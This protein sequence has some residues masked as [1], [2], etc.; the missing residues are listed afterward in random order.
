MMK[1]FLLKE[2]LR[3]V[4]PFVWMGVVFFNTVDLRPKVSDDFFFASDDPE[5][6]ENNEIFYLFPE[7][8]QPVIISAVGDIRSK[9]YQKKARQFTK[10]LETLPDSFGVQSI[11]NGPKKLLR[12][13]CGGGS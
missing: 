4:I 3:N 7:L 8:S 11:T 13:P 2:I 12:A 9:A 6:Q 10:T 5:F 1:K